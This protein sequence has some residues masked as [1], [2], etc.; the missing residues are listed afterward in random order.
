VGTVHLALAHRL[1]DEKT[2]EIVHK[3]YAI[4]FARDQVRILAAWW[5][6][7]MVDKVLP[8]EPWV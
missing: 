5:A 8:K 3:T 7:A 6:L 4:G 1:G 2:M